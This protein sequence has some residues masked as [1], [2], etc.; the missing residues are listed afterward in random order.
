MRKRFVKIAIAVVLLAAFLWSPFSNYG[1]SYIVM[2][3]YSRIH[4][5]KS[6]MEEK[7]ISLRIPGGGATEE[8]DW[9]PFVMTFHPGGSFGRFIGEENVNLT[10]LYNFPAFDV[11]RGCS[12]LYNPDSPY[13]NSFYGAY[14]V[15]GKTEEGAPYGFLENGSLDPDS[16][17]EVP[18]Y[19]FQRLVLEDMGIKKNQMVFDWEITGMEENVS[20]AGSSGWTRVDADL[21]VNGVLHVKEEFHR[22]YLQYGPPSYALEGNEA[23]PFEPVAM[24]GRI[25]GKY[26]SQWETGVFFY[27]LASEQSVLEICDQE[28]L[29]HSELK[30]EGGRDG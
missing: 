21:L 24:K 4:Q 12:L 11:W 1:I 13:Y 2:K 18:Q 20:Y 22:S 28:I 30:K 9:Y 6:L 3:G 23:E 25:Y 17:A 14:L 15:S 7:G 29:S 5:Q 27:I 8:K 26:F 16:V 19:D 10:I